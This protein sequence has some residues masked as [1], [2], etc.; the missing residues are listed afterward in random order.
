MRTNTK[1]RLV[2]ASLTL[3]ALV[4]SVFGAVP[5]WTSG[6]TEVSGD[7]S[8]T[9]D[10]TGSP[11]ITTDT[12]T[13]P[14]GQTLTI[15]PGVVVEFH[16]RGSCSG[17]YWF[18]IQGTLIA[19]GTAT[20]R[21]TFTGI[22]KEN[23]WEGIRFSS[24]ATS[25]VLEHC[26]IERFTQWGINMNTVYSTTSNSVSIK[27]CIFR[28]GDNKDTPCG[29][30]AS[31]AI[32][33]VF[34][35]PVVENNL[36]HDLEFG[37]ML[38]FWPFPSHRPV[39]SGNEFRDTWSAISLYD[40]DDAELTANTITDSFRAMYIDNSSPL[41]QEN[42]VS[43]N[44][45]GIFVYLS[46]DPLIQHNDFYGNSDFALKSFSGEALR[47]EDNWWGSEYG[48]EHT[49]ELGAAGTIECESPGEGG[50]NCDGCDT[51][52]LPTGQLGDKII[53]YYIWKEVTY[54]TTVDYCP[55]LTESPVVDLELAK[56]VDN[57]SPTVGEQVMFTITISNTESLDATGVQVK[58][59]YRSGPLTYGSTQGVDYSTSVGTYYPITVTWDIGDLAEGAWATLYL[60]ATVT[61]TGTF[62]NFAEV[63]A[64]DQADPDSTPDNF[65]DDPFPY[66]DDTGWASGSGQPTAVTLSSFAARSSAGGLSARPL[67]LGL[68]GLTVLATGSLLWTKRR[69]G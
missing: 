8:G 59:F 27:N 43:F 41:I 3:V 1:F 63:I 17:N 30:G 16:D 61:E 33:A 46:G 47:A 14:S 56:D 28:Y 40:M 24:G 15:E 44:T 45:E 64:C 34:S 42:I 12:I 10:L 58:D 32:S 36:F 19:I 55:W 26:I 54:Y 35:N 53:S 5:A 6:P 65:P 21:I 4:L 37:V 23:C 57:A 39:V 66:E 29:S 31:W 68:A 38:V 51:N 49:V 9:W 18:D 48:P 7:V 69:I 13:V 25:S 50:W 52:Q 20:D 67:C 11:Y 62:E 2:L 60:T 22:T